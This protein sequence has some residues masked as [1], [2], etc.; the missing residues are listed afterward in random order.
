MY[1]FEVM[2]E[3]FR[4]I[5]KVANYMQLRKSYKGVELLIEFECRH[6]GSQIR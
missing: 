3:L 6:V 5:Q 2:N 1:V 4:L